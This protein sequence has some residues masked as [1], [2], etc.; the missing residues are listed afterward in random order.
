MKSLLSESES[1]SLHSWLPDQGSL[2]QTTICQRAAH[3][4]GVG[5]AG[6][7]EHTY[8][9]A[10]MVDTFV[11]PVFWLHEPSKPKALTLVPISETIF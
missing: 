2:L 10:G 1:V 9:K 11:K 4:R 8:G 3:W 6:D 5:E 7:A